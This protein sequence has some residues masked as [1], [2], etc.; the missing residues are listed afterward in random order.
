[1]YALEGRMQLLSQSIFTYTTLRRE[2]VLDAGGASS[3]W[4]ST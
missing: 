2:S 1:M 4:L 3:Q